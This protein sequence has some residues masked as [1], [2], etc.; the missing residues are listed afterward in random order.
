MFEKEGGAAWGERHGGHSQHR[1]CS[2][3]HGS[4]PALAPTIKCL[5]NLKRNPAL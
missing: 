4:S 2:R 5:N 1:S 3:R